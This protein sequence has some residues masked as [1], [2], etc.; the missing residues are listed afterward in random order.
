MSSQP[1]LSSSFNV[2]ETCNRPNEAMYISD[3]DDE[4]D[5]DDD[6]YFYRVSLRKDLISV[7]PL[8]GDGT[9]VDE[10]IESDVKCI[11]FHNK[12]SVT[13]I[14]SHRDYN[15]KEKK[16]LW[17]SLEEI[18][19]SAIK[20]QMELCMDGEDD[21]Y[22]DATEDV[23]EEDPESRRFIPLQRMEMAR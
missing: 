9:T 12:V 17:T 10:I 16:Q 21:Y 18:R 15:E 23:E 4:S 1:P 20:N 14:P 6:E 7:E 8:K 13:L 19:V 2:N 3:D 5:D 22:E 11:R